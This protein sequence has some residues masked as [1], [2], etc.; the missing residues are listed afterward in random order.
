[1]AAE[2]SCV[3]STLWWRPI[4]AY[5]VKADLWAA[6]RRRKPV[7]G[8][9]VVGRLARAAPQ[10]T[11]EDIFLRAS[12]VHGSGERGGVGQISDTFVWAL[13]HLASDTGLAG[14]LRENPNDITV[15]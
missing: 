10:G 7:G 13:R 12:S 2:S 11:E 5:Q 3:P 4:F 1:M 9:A 14:R 8:A 15:F 6:V